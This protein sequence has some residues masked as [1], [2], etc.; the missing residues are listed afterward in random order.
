MRQAI[1][2]S[3]FHRASALAGLLAML[4][5]LAGCAGL[6]GGPSSAQSP[7]YRCDNNIEFTARFVDDSV[8]L[9]S[10]RGYEVL[11]RDAGG[12]TDRQ[13]FFSNPKMKAEFGLGRTG[14]EAI[15]RYPLLPLVARCVLTD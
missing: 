4:T 15:L 8:L 7:L 14:R 2:T 13:R 1:S 3:S 12:V 9:D 11:F 6:Q 5:F 10:T